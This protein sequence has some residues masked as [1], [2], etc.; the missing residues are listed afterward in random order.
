M[1]YRWPHGNRCAVVLSFDVDAESGHV[2]SAPEEAATR[3]DT[4][5]E[6]R[7][8]VRTG[9]PRILRLLEKYALPATFFVPGYTIVHHTNV[10]RT[11]LGSGYEMGCHGNVHEAVHMLDAEAERRVLQEQLDIYERYLGIQPKGYRSPSWSVN[12]RTPGLLKE[13][14]FVYDSSLMGDDVPYFLDT[15]HGRLVEVPVQWL[16]DDAPFYRHVYGATNAIAEPDRVV[17]LWTQEF[18]GMHGE[19]GC[20]VL[21][22][23]PYISGRA[24]RIDGLERLIRTMRQEPGVWFATAMQ[25][26]EWAIETNQNADLK[27]PVG[28]SADRHSLA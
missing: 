25:V 4:M 21:T 15:P 19:N 8:G 14:G 11:I 18:L 10:V 3:L 27:V 17:G 6:R 26:A 13:F 12:V 1:R 23:H 7:F 9:V 22:M 24:S 2:F 20:F 5:E 28:D 16:L